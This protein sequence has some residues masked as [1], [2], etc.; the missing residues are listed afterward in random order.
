MCDFGLALIFLDATAT[1]RYFRPDGRSVIK[2]GA[3]GKP[4]RGWTSPA[5]RSIPGRLDS[6]QCTRIT[7][8][9][10]VIQIYLTAAG[11]IFGFWVSNHKAHV[12]ANAL[13]DATKSIDP[14]RLSEAA[15]AVIDATNAVIDRL[16]AWGVTALTCY[17]TA[18]VIMHNLIIQE[19]TE[20]MSLCEYHARGTIKKS[21]SGTNDLFYFHNAVH[22][23]EPVG[24]PAPSRDDI[25]GKVFTFHSNHRLMHRLI[26]V[27]ILGITNTAAF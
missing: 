21:G 5:R 18:L 10:G 2:H 11:V 1:L 6:E 9:Q 26:L 19:L 7:Q 25:V 14:A 27:L 16:L 20:F 22:D 3:G 17:S 24:S 23:K 8:R 15:N 4:C 12:A 13:I